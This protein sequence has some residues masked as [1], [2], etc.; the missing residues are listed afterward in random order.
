MMEAK[1]SLPSAAAAQLLAEAG[2]ADG[3]PAAAAAAPAEPAPPAAIAAPAEPVA[4]APAAAPT[5]DQELAGLAAMIGATLGEFF[6]ST[7]A[8]MTEEKCGELAAALSPVIQK[9]GLERHFMGFAWRVELKAAM[10]VVPVVIAMRAAIGQ[11]LATAGRAP[12]PGGAPLGDRA[13]D[14][15]APPAPGSAPAAQMLKP[16]A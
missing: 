8:I 2:R 1:K 3:D 7:K 6:P 13:A 5:L 9:Y 16:I 10:V 11:D 4:P 14:G 12:A 15:A